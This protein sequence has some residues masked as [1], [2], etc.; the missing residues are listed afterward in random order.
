MGTDYSITN[1]TGTV[2]TTTLD[3]G[4]TLETLC[5]YGTDSAITYIEYDTNSAVNPELTMEI[6]IKL[7]AYSGY[8]WTLTHDD[9]EFDRAIMV[10]DSR[11]DGIAAGVGGLYTSTVDE[12]ALDEWTHIVVTW[13]KANGEAVVY[14]NGG[15]LADDGTQQI[16]S[17]VDDSGSVYTR[18]GLNG[19]GDY[20]GTIDHEIEGCF[21][22][23]QMTNRVVNA[24]EVRDLYDVFDAVINAPAPP[25]ADPTLDPSA[26]P[27]RS[28]TFNPSLNPTS[29]APTTTQPTTV[30]PTAQPTTTVIPTLTPSN[31]PTLPPSTEPTIEPTMNPSRSPTFDPSSDPTVDPTM[32]PSEHPSTIPSSFP[33]ISPSSNPSPEPTTLSITSNSPIQLNCSMRLNADFDALLTLTNSSNMTMVSVARA[34]IRSGFTGISDV[35][36][37]I[38]EVRRGSVIIDYTL[39]SNSES[40]LNSA[41]SSLNSSI[42]DAIVIGNVTFEYSSNTIY[43][44]SPTAAPTADPT[45]DPT[46]DPSTA[47]TKS[48]STPQPSGH[49]TTSPST[50]PTFHPT[51]NPTRGPT[52]APTRG[53]VYCGQKKQGTFNGEWEYY[54]HIDND[55]IVTFET[56][57]SYLNL[58]SM[59]IYAINGSNNTLFAECIECGSICLD[60]SKFRAEMENGT[61]LLTI[62]QKHQFKMI[63]EAEPHPTMEPTEPLTSASPTANPSSNPTDYPTTS[64]PTVQEIVVNV[65]V[66]DISSSTTYLSDPFG[67]FEASSSVLIQDE[68]GVLGDIGGCSSCFIWQYRSDGD[69][70][71]NTF[72]VLGNDDISVSL[73]QTDGEFTCNLVVQSIRRSNA[74]NCVDD[75]DIA[76]HPFE[77]DTDYH[78]RMKFIS[79]NGAYFVSEISNELSF[80]TNGLPANGIC[81]VQNIHKLLPLDPYN[82]FCDEWDDDD[83]LE[84]NA[85]ID[86][87][88]MS[89]DGFVDDARELTGIAPSGNVSITVLVKEQNEYNAI[90]CYQIEATF[91]SM[92]DILSD[93]RGNGTEDEV[94][95]D[96]LVT[97]DNI[98]N[99]TSLAEN[100]D[101]AV[102][103]HSVVVDLYQSNLTT[104][105]EAEQIVD[106]MVVNILE[107]STV[108]S[109]SNESSLNITGDAIITELAT[110][111]SITSNQEIV[112]AESTTTQL[113]EEYLPDIFEAVDL[114]IDVSEDN[115][116]SNISS[117]EVQDALYSIGEQSQELITNLEATLVDFINTA[118]ATDRAI[119]SVNSLSES[120]VDFA[121]LAASTALAR[122]DIGETFNYEVIEY[123]DNGN[124]VNSKTVSASKFSANHTSSVKPSCGS[125]SENIEIPMT[126]MM[127]QSIG[128]FDC[129]LMTS[130]RNN[131]V[132]KGSNNM[133]REQKSSS[134]VTANLYHSGSSSQRRRLSETIEFQTSR[135]SPYLITMRTRDDTKYDLNLS[136]DDSFDFPSCDFWN[137]N[138]SYWDTA[139]CFVYDIT[140]ES[141]VCGCTHLTTF[142]MSASDVLP[143]VNKLTGL[144]WH[145]FSIDNLLHYPVVWVTCLCIFIIF[146]VICCWNPGSSKVH[147]RS[148]LGMRY[149]ISFL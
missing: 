96:I 57:S 18:V 116:S 71:W 114:F 135:C 54:L 25:T 8:G 6:W 33:T 129:A 19:A 3:G 95:E 86:G 110:V 138:D 102:S 62:D 97:I 1:L 79:P 132:P 7:S 140:N 47:P 77:A 49:P 83:N 146:V 143:E 16:V 148:I 34:I 51:V 31:I 76:N 84:Y 141:V 128:T 133:D 93:I 87:V 113:V 89:T 131:F 21:G 46:S 74:G 4:D 147:V 88:V 48:P 68:D 41:T 42:G 117:T 142:S 120:L 72:D 136:L 44:T 112:D 111:T 69:S 5:F 45:R 105:S 73:T 98:T 108:V 64:H 2:N 24:S 91:K 59:R 119:D 20:R 56:C 67:R 35:I 61:Y 52:T 40:S 29:A 50:N 145:E 100:P 30:I 101:V 144:G 121:T 38:L 134:I 27:T 124:A 63:C 36:I 17:I 115:D 94:V 85:L 125:T 22:Q 70:E 103:I 53:D 118:N 11:F 126:L 14:K 137:T 109:S 26:V 78:L 65:S 12:P 66:G 10:Y 99:S 82:L 122:S 37:T 15:S 107:T 92:D 106:D 75:E 139:G 23:V 32:E 55:S 58:F 104:Q 149:S 39:S 80:S 123:D 130:T 127:D 81:I 43:T 28:P 13:S 9:W 90:T 60:Q